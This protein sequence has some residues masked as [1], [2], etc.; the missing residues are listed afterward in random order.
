MIW[1]QLGEYDG[2]FYISEYGDVFN[3]LT[4]NHI[5][6]WVNNNGYKY[7]DLNYKGKRYRWLIHRLVATVF[8]PNPNNFPIVLHLDNNPLNCHISNLKWGTYSDNNKQAVKEGRMIV[9][10]PDNRKE[11]VLYHDDACFNVIC[12]GMTEIINRLGFGNNSQIRN[13]IHRNSSIP[14]GSFKGWKIKL[15]DNSSTFN[16][17][18]LTRE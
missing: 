1:K 16:D 2:V 6:Q 10:K 3:S 8:I 18:P 11:Y 17:H 14:K 13:Y 7:T 12:N 4:G 9:P 5:H 15:K